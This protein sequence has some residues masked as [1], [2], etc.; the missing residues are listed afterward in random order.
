MA[1]PSFTDEQ[2][3]VIE[4]MEGPLDVSAGAGSGKTFT[5]SQRIA[6]AIATP[7]SGVESIDEVLAITFTDKAASE[8]KSRVRSTLRAYG[9]FDD[10]LKVDSAWIST[11]HGACA[12][13]LRAHAL[14]LGIDPG[15]AVLSEKRRAE[16]INEAV[17]EV[18]GPDS[19]IVG[20]AAGFDALFRA[21]PARSNGFGAS[22]TSIVEEL[23][24][25]ASG[26][27]D[28][29]DGFALPP[30]ALAPGELA[31]RLLL[32]YEGMLDAYAG[33]KEG[34]TIAKNRA[35]AEAAIEALDGFIASGGKTHEGL[36]DALDGCEFL[37]KIPR[38]LTEETDAY[39]QVHAQVAREAYFALARPLLDEALALARRAHERYDAA[40]RAAGA[41]DNDDL[42]KHALA[43]LSLP[44]AEQE[45]AG[46]FKLVMVD[47]FQDTNQLQ[48][49]IV[50]RLAGPGMRYL[51]TVGDAQQSIYRF[52]GADVN[53]YR[54]YRASL[55]GEEVR[56]AG[57]S[58]SLA[59]LSRNF[60][61]H[62][63][64]LAFVKR[65]CAQPC[66]FGKD[67][68]DLAAVYDG[69]AYRACEPRIQIA[70]VSTPPGARGGSGEIVAA[71]ARAIAQYFRRMHDAGHALSE[72]A[73]LLGRMTHA[74]TYAQAIRDEGFPC[75]IAGG[76]LFARA[77]EVRTVSQLARALADP[78]DSLELF[79][80]LTSDM[81]ELSADDLLELATGFDEV[82]GIPVKRDLAKGFALLAE[83]A[84]ALSPGLA[85]AVEVFANAR[86]A[87]RLRRPSEALTGAILD[88]G[89]IA[90]LEREGAEG[91][92]RIANILKAVRFFEQM[93]REEGFGMAR[94]AAE[95]SE[96]LEAGMKEAPGALSAE[97]Q[98]AVRIMTIHASKGLEFPVVALAR[99]ARSGQ[100]RASALVAEAVGSA[101]LL[102]LKPPETLLRADARSAK[103]FGKPFAP[104]E[105]DAAACLAGGEGLAAFHAA[106]AARA[107]AEQLAEEQRLF[108]V[109][110]TRAKEA[111]LVVMGLK[112]SK[113]D[114]LGAY[115]GVADDVRS[116]LA[117]AEPLPD[118]AC[119]LDY[120]GSEPAAF[121]RIVVGG[122][123]E[124]ADPANR[125]EGASAG[126]AEG[127][128]PGECRTARADAGAIGEGGAFEAEGAV[129]TGRVAL[130]EVE[131]FS[132]FATV[133]PEKPARPFFSYTS[134]AA[135]Q[136]EGGG[137]QPC[138]AGDA[139]DDGASGQTELRGEGA[140]AQPA[141]STHALAA[142]DAEGEREGFEPMRAAA[143][144]D[145]ATDFGSAF[146]RAAQLAAL[147][148]P[149]FARARLDALARTYA[150]KEPARLSCA[151]ER[152]VSSAV[153]ARALS[154]RR[155]DAE[156]P[157]CV[158]TEA[159]LLEGEIDLLCTD[160]SA[161]EGAHVLV[162]DYKTGGSA[163]ETPA[164]LHEKHLLQAQCYAYA[165]IAQGCVEVEFA[166]V[167]VERDDPA[168]ADDLE[169][170]PY[171]FTREDR[172]ALADAIAHC[173]ARI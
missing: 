131:P 72:M 85:H 7:G 97:G 136:G 20:A 5:L 54:A 112:E 80:A 36:L 11:I 59:A 75:V 37:S 132:L 145:K 4:R 111:L 128:E 173:A 43:A 162:V 170:V 16:M 83:R 70:A 138:G 126:G 144:A 62:A 155:H 86:E 134:L 49:E 64:V 142:S 148:S 46:R 24:S 15:F 66:V 93:E 119:S 8:I 40:K 14:E 27:V 41:L 95:F 140:A 117:G 79:G 139:S 121:S 88:S 22:V 133:C 55:E 149:E 21:F 141:P 105:E 29:F 1:A 42:L 154:M 23:I 120:G 2:R 38:A 125:A 116:A 100:G 114:P 25:K 67:F 28:G 101:T 157:F 31:R 92:A 81:F 12:R 156:V 107:D 91:Q 106:L 118:A 35:F 98:D 104:S 10:A 77:P 52:R 17:A 99:F 68:L 57:G 19:E 102:S 47:E 103:A 164:S 45:W 159:G 39:Q 6:H 18:I 172:P 61:S 165:L 76:S 127:A 171:R 143:D 50:R 84:D 151:F 161:L 73:V 71:E 115:K 123:A 94:C 34:K 146:H 3:Y 74:E 69:A 65:V 167:R 89:W 96:M 56:L 13:I 108:Y 60:R 82:H 124:A 150:L 109:G 78:F 48:I 110:A 158:P 153:C 130:P 33:A 163:S 147:V 30:A 122:G 51:C 87:V 44:G 58:P 168:G 129:P 26:M 90:R 9:L 152:W 169:V 137:A 113:S 32:A 166:F 53:V 63:D 160:A 135:S